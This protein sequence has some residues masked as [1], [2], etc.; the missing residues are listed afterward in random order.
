MVRNIVR[1]VLFLAQKST[2]AGKEDA[3][4]IKDLRDTLAA[5]R[6]SCVGMAAN[7][8]GVSKRI[9][10]FSTELGDIVMINPQIVSK[11]ASYDTEEGCLSL[12][13]V[14]KVKRFKNISVRY[15]DES[16]TARKG[17]FSG[18]TAQIIQHECDHLD[19]III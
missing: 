9:I 11:N 10:I 12:V 2:P 3:E 7:M 6:E 5:N 13:G 4:V 19:G 8:I 14:R 17:N 1:D 18:F 15:L 16:F